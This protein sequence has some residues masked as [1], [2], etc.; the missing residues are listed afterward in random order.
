MEL[1]SCGSWFDT[2]IAVYTGTCSSLT[3]IACNDDGATCPG[4]GA[5]RVAFT[6][7]CGQRYF[8]RIGPK[9]GQ[10]GD[11]ALI[12]SNAQSTACP[13]CPADLDHSGT[14]DSQDISILL[15]AWGTP[16]ADLN[17]DGTTSSPDLA[18]LLNAWG[19]CN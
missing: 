14:I 17:G 18:V 13:V 19:A 8:F 1:R 5:S 16:T 3:A 15:N 9:S 6:A 12:L 2:V 11:V 7:Q 4:I 10:G